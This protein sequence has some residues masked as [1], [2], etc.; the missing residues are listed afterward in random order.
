M[1]D[2]MPLGESLSRFREGAVNK[3]SALPKQDRSQQSFDQMRPANMQF[4][5][6]LADVDDLS[7]VYG[8]RDRVQRRWEDVNDSGRPQSG[9]GSAED[10]ATLQIVEDARVQDFSFLISSMN[11]ITWRS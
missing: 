9:F 6:Q 10:L 11:S 7:N 4:G 5:G 8:A 2:F 3:D 1:T